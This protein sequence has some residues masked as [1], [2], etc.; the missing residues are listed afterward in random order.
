MLPIK[1]GGKVIGGHL[2]AAERKALDIEVRKTFAEYDRKNADELDAIFLWYLH[3]KL[4]FSIEQLKD[5]YFDLAPSIE[6]LCEQYDM[7]G[8]GD[9]TWLCTYKLKEIGVDIST[10]NEELGRKMRENTL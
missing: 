10:W 2:S 4:S 6:S 9:L 8:S 7:N 3:E 5:A 1:S